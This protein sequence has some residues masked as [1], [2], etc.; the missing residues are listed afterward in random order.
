MYCYLYTLSYI[1]GEKIRSL[2]VIKNYIWSVY[3]RWFPSSNHLGPEKGV[4]QKNAEHST[5]LLNI[6]PL[7]NILWTSLLFCCYHPW[8]KKI[9]FLCNICMFSSHFAICICNT[10]NCFSSSTRW[11]YFIKLRNFLCRYFSFLGCSLPQNNFRPDLAE[12]NYSLSDNNLHHNSLLLYFP[13]GQKYS[14]SY[15]F[16]PAEQVPPF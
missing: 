2:K 8:Q 5:K 3:S 14:S 15:N 1:L 13:E 16:S 11:D 12:E 7:N 6:L 10:R 9:S 4:E